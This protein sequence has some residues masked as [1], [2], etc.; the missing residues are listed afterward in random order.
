MQPM[1]FAI[2]LP[3]ERELYREDG[4]FSY[5]KMYHR[6]DSNNPLL[7]IYVLDKDSEVSTQARQTRQRLFPSEKEDREH[8]VALAIAFP[9]ANLSNEERE[10]QVGYW[11][12]GGMEHEPNNEP[13]G[14]G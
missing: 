5:T 1:H 11:A 13:E 2:D 6:R 7:V 12:Q 9:E 10:A 14:D 3:G 4:K 8:I